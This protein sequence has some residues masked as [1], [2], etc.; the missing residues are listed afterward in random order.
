MLE[1]K[2]RLSDLVNFDVT[3]AWLQAWTSARVGAAVPT[4][5]TLTSA[6]DLQDHLVIYLSNPTELK[7]TGSSVLS[8]ALQLN[9]AGETFP[10]SWLEQI[11]NAFIQ[12]AQEKKMALGRLVFPGAAL[13]VEYLTLPVT[14][15]ESDRPLCIS[16]MVGSSTRPAFS[17]GRLIDVRVLD[18]PQ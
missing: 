1:V 9:R 10:E 4:A 8:L 2:D 15:R 16:S 5:N 3:R 14:G 11:N 6:A 18:V 7:Y 13:A 12:V 17:G